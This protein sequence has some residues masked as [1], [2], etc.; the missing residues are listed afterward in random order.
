MK[1]NNN[2]THGMSFAAALEAINNDTTATLSEKIA[3]VDS[4]VSQLR[5]YIET[6]P[7]RSAW[8][9]GVVY[10][11]GYLLENFAEYAIF[12][13][14]NGR[15]VPVLS[16]SI[17]LNGAADWSAYSYGGCAL[18]YDEEIADTLCSPSELRR[19]RGGKHQPNARETWCDVQARALCQAWHRIRHALKFAEIH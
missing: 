18:V 11:V 9:R 19:T 8:A 3:R 17:L 13:L 2:E 14:E 16:E 6:L 15:P 4:I 5:V 12:E 1:T 10:Y 7:T